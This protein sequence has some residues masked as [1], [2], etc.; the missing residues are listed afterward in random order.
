MKTRLFFSAFIVS[1][2]LLFA[3]RIETAKQIKRKTLS[4]AVLIGMN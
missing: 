2:I 4:G 3:F 1:A